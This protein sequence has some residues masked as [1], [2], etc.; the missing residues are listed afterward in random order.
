MEAI[1]VI[2]LWALSLTTVAAI[3]FALRA[4]WRIRQA[5]E[6]ARFAEEAFEELFGKDRNRRAAR[7]AGTRE[8]ANI[9]SILN[10]R[11]AA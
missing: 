6:R 8:L 3:A 7:A 9:R 4:W 10:P 11:S 5:E 1:I 2:Y